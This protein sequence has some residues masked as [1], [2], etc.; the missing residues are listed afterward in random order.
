[1]GC[2]EVGFGCILDGLLASAPRPRLWV[3]GLGVWE[4]VG[5]GRVRLLES[6]R[7]P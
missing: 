7:W 6:C 3:W 1:L 5:V 2:V 4:R